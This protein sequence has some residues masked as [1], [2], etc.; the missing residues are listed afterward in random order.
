MRRGGLSGNDG[1]DGG[2][3]V[4]GAVVPSA[5]C[6]VF[7]PLAAVDPSFYLLLLLFFKTFFLPR[8]GCRARRVCVPPPPS[9]IDFEKK[10]ARAHHTLV[11]ST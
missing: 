4:G 1:R 3:G 9:D 10:R 2:T 5:V 8:C 11:P 6:C 7:S